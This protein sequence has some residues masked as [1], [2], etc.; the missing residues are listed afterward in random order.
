[1]EKK[2]KRGLYLFIDLEKAYDRVPKGEVWRCTSSEGV[3]E[4]YIRLVQDMYREATMKVNS[5]V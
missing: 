1:M 3:R 4:K 5:A 2:K